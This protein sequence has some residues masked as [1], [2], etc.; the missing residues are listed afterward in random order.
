[1]KFAALGLHSLLSSAS[2]GLSIADSTVLA[3]EL[4]PCKA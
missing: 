2:A 1:M 4:P 3:I